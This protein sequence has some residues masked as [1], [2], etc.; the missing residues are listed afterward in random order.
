MRTKRRRA[1]ERESGTGYIVSGVILLCATVAFVVFGRLAAPWPAFVALGAGATLGV[2]LFR[3][4]S[5]RVWVSQICL[6]GALAV[7]VALF[8]AANTV[9]SAGIAWIG[10][11]VAG[12]NLGTGWRLEATRRAPSHA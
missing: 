5:R 10:S 3:S 11:F 12:T 1:R 8:M 4:G 2:W 7:C 6:F 9:G